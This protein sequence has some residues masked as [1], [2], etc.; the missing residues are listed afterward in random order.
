M[1]G[2]KQSRAVALLLAALGGCAG[3]EL[4][5][6]PRSAEI[7]GA[8]AVPFAGCLPPGVVSICEDPVSGASPEAIVDGGSLL[9]TGFRVDEK[10]NHVTFDLGE[11]AVD[12]RIR[13]TLTGIGPESLAQD[14]LLVMLATDTPE[15]RNPEPTRV[16]E[17]KI[18]GSAVDP[19]AEGNTRYGA[20]DLVDEAVK[21]AGVFDYDPT[22]TYE[23]EASWD[24]ATKRLT[25]A[26]DGEMLLDFVP[27]DPIAMRYRYVHL[28]MPYMPNNTFWPIM[29]GVY[30][31]VSIAATPASGGGGGESS[32]GADGGPPDA[33]G[34][35]TSSDGDAEI[36]S[37][38]SSEG[39]EAESTGVDAT[40]SGP[41]NT[42]PFPT[43]GVR[44]AVTG[45]GCTSGRTRGEAVLAMALLLLLGCPPLSSARARDRSRAGSCPRRWSR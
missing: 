6:R 26:M 27:S 31:S 3:D 14:T 4:D 34:S 39:G 33:D 44:G 9:P 43:A 11:D 38:S 7:V 10:G 41:S 15:L 17:L 12:G 8:D 29:D 37:T 30:G 40:T 45:C 16:L 1:P 22:R 23:F 2:P 13:F 42:T 20:G 35:G 32:T 25:L 19:S 24:D 36:P 5:P 21:P 28:A 18:W